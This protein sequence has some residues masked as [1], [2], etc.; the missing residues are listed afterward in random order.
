MNRKFVPFWF[1][2]L[3]AF[4]FLLSQVSV[5]AQTESRITSTI[6]DSLLTLKQNKSPEK[7]P[8]N[9]KNVKYFYEPFPLQKGES[10]FQIGG[11]FSLLPIPI[12]EQEYP[13]PAID[14]QYKYALANNLCFV[15]S[16]STLLHYY[17]LVHVGIQWNVNSDRLSFGTATHFGF[18]FGYMDDSDNFDQ[19]WAIGTFWMPIVRVGYRF[20]HFSLTFSFVTTLNIY[21]HSK[22]NDVKSKPGSDG[23]LNDFFCTVTVEQPFLKNQQVAVGFSF[24]YSRTPYQSWMLYNTVNEWLFV[25]EFFFSVQL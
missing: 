19:V 7:L 5:I 2:A 12:T 14:L 20:N 17:D 18:A 4:P 10:V 8:D 13:I 23:K 25:P 15:S 22:V 16:L 9:L 21:S 1:V 11:S 6:N 24:A 3:L